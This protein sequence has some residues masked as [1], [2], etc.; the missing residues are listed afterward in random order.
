MKRKPLSRLARRS[1][2]QIHGD[3]KTDRCGA[4]LITSADA[5]D[6][7]VE[8]SP[9]SVP[10]LIVAVVTGCRN[11]L[12]SES[13]PKHLEQKTHMGNHVDMLELNSQLK[14]LV[15]ICNVKDARK[16]FDKRPKQDAVS[17]T[18]MISG[19]ARVSDSSKALA[20]FSNMWVQ[21][22]VFTR[23]SSVCG[24]MHST[25]YSPSLCGKRREYHALYMFDKMLQSDGMCN[26][27]RTIIAPMSI[28]DKGGGLATHRD[29]VDASNCIRDNEALARC[30]FGKIS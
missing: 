1:R 12:V 22:Q 10:V 3:S 26:V 16:M 4:L 6:V 23:V 30:C 29:I 17:W 13:T 7:P 9:A 14:Q 2:T 27:G 5:F 25:C 28:R 8:T 24:T 20:L 11:L 18:S 15:K 21:P 19:Y